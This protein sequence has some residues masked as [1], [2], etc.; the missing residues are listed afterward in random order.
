MSASVFGTND[1]SLDLLL[2][3]AKETLARREQ[4]KIAAEQAAG[5]KQTSKKQQLALSVPLRLDTG[6]RIGESQLLKTNR[7]TGMTTLNTDL[8]YANA[9]AAPGIDSAIDE[10]TATPDPTIKRQ[11]KNT[12][13]AAKDQT[14]GKQWFGMKAPV[15][16]Q[17]LKND[18]RVL[19]L[20]NILDPKRFYKK[21]VSTKK[22]PKYFEMGTIIEGPT[23]FYSSRMT[24]KERKNNLVD[25]LLADKQAR[26]YFK[27]K[28]G[29][30]NAVNNSGRNRKHFKKS[31][32]SG[33][34]SGGHK[35]GDKAKRGH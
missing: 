5:N 27:R 7:T 14:A 23:E 4:D 31:K 29:E 2:S 28:V 9:K 8:V 15:L 33:N 35:S 19:Q 16:T 13:A 30:I 11:S 21:D 3:Q 18:V 26:D 24:K 32:G 22:M 12:V 20:R 10:K 6:C 34:A 25:E 1:S 17:E